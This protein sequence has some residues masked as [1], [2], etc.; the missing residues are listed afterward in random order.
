V[1]QVV[2]GL[3]GGIGSGKSRL[4]AELSRRGGR[5]LS[6]DAYGHEALRQ[7][8]IKSAIIQRWGRDVCDASGE[9]DRRRLGAQVFADVKERKA[10]E[11]LSFPWIE[12]RFAEEIDAAR[13][14]L[15]V[16]MIVVDAAILLEAGWDRYCDRIVFVWAPRAVRLRRLAEQRGWSET[17]VTAR[18]SAQ[19]SLT[20]KV[21][22]ADAAID[23]SGTLDDLQRQVDQLLERW[24]I[25][26][27]RQ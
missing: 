6:A 5:V 11:A 15:A 27:K 23:N 14:D 8:A 13:R 25:G 4:S 2:I 1:Q 12:G 18:E 20:E 26:P 21:S 19:M 9:V 10:L 17:E 3:I 22:R 7:P 16:S 24:S